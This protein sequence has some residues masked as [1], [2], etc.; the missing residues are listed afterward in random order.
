LLLGQLGSLKQIYIHLAK[1][2]FKIDRMNFSI[3]SYSV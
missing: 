2:K 3:F 1:K